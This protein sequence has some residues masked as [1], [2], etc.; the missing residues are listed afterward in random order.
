MRWK[1]H[2]RLWRHWLLLVL[3][4]AEIEALPLDPVEV[5]TEPFA[6]VEVLREWEHIDVLVKVRL[7]SGEEW[8]VCIENKVNARQS[9]GQLKRYREVVQRIFPQARRVFIFLTRNEEAPED[10]EQAHYVSARYE[11]IKRTLDL[12]LSEAHD[13]LGAGPRYLIEQYNHLINER[14]M[15]NSKERELALKIYQEH[16]KALDYIFEQIPDKLNEVGALVGGL[17]KNAGYWTKS[18]KPVV[19]LPNEWRLPQNMAPNDWPRV[20]LEIRMSEDK[21]VVRH[22]PVRS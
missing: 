6:R 18:N 14:F 8:V 1:P 16:R 5:D 10:Q 19:F 22:K 21:V 15:Q 20:C 4:E 12:C 2:L 3:N 7:K 17:V 9:K 11:T 13:A